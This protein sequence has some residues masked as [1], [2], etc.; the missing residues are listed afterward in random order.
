MPQIDHPRCERF[1][2]GACLLDPA[3]VPEVVALLVPGDFGNPL[4]RRLFEVI[5]ATDPHAIDLVTVADHAE[6]GLDEI[7]SLLDDTVSAAA[8]R[9]FVGKLRES[10]R[11]KTILN[12]AATAAANLKKPEKPAHETAQRAIDELMAEIGESF[13]AKSKRGAEL[14]YPV[15][16]ELDRRADPNYDH[17]PTFGLEDL[18]G[19][20]C[21][22]SDSTLTLLAA[23]PSTGKSALAVQ[24]ALQAAREKRRVAFVSLEMSA[25]D[26]TARFLAQI[27][28]LCLHRMLKGHLS[29]AERQRLMEA[30]ETFAAMQVCVLD[31]STSS[32]A[33]IRAECVKLSPG[34]VIVDYLQ[35][36]TP[37]KAETRNEEVSKISRALKRLAMET[38]KPVVALSQLSRP[39]TPRLPRLTDL[40]DSGSLEQDAD[41][42]VMLH[43]DTTKPKERAAIVAKQRNGPTGQVTLF[44]HAEQARFDNFTRRPDDAQR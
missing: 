7:T 44:W 24:L 28:K 33:E 5:A 3:I 27:G 8:W 19:I 38:R 36:V 11:R 41:V 14:V 42:V 35:L 12:I 29:P 4:H 18:D 26:I 9:Y 31:A 25:L 13:D 1:V 40:R 39:E 32:V 43:L 37:E 15:L 17:G 22:L 2:L 20:L 16:E 23:R 30:G 34:L 6:W 21:G 10:R